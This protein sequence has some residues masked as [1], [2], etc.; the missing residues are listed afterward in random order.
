VWAKFVDFGLVPSSHCAAQSSSHRAHTTDCH[1]GPTSSRLPRARFLS[2]PTCGTYLA[3][4]TISRSGCLFASMT[5]GLALSSLTSATA[6]TESS[7][8]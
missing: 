5:G 1:L 3:A 7:A 6:W 8:T 4:P 2:L